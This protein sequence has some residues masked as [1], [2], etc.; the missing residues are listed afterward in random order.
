MRIPFA[1][2]AALAVLA[3]TLPAF[4][5]SETPAA[6]APK[7]IVKHKTVSPVAHCNALKT[8]SARAACLKRLHAQ[9]T[10]AKPPAKT[11]T[12]TKKP[13][14]TAQLTPR[15]PT[16]IP[17]PAP[18]QAQAP[19]APTTQPTPPQTISVPPLPQKTI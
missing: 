4:A 14:T 17:T 1:S 5:Q 2:L 13:A 8:S 6:P 10:H 3:V 16:P 19:A 9:A 15:D 18:S 12:K 11:T 7:P